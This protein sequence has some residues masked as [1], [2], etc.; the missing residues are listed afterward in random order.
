MTQACWL[1]ASLCE[2]VKPGM[3]GWQQHGC[4]GPVKWQLRLGK[5][6]V[7]FRVSAMQTAEGKEIVEEGEKLERQGESAKLGQSASESV[8]VPVAERLKADTGQTQ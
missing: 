3:A 2:V 5:G 7:R 1:M 8:T 4:R 6:A